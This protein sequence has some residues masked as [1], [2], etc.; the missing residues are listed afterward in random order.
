MQPS[1]EMR[2]DLL[3]MAIKY[4]QESGCACGPIEMYQAFVHALAM[5]P[6]KIEAEVQAQKAE[7]ILRVAN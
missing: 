4:V 1:I 2:L 5:E 6:D 3:K 7:M